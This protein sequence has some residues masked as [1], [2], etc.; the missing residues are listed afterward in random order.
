MWGNNMKRVR[1]TDAPTYCEFED[2]MTRISVFSI[3]VLIGLPLLFGLVS[4]L[5][6][7]TFPSNEAV[8]RAAPSPNILLLTID[9]LRAD[10][11][12]CY[13]Y[14]RETSPVIDALAAEGARFKNAM[15][16][17]GLTWPSLASLMTS[18]YP[19]QHGVRDNGD[20]LAPEHIQLP[21]L[22]GDKGYDTVA[23]LSN[24]HLQHWEGWDLLEHGTDE[25]LTE[26]AV[27]WLN[28]DRPA[29]FFLWLHLMAP[30]WNYTP[31][32]PYDTQFDA[33][34]DG[35]LD[36][37]NGSYVVRVTE[38]GQLSAR[39]VAHMGALYDGEVRYAD[40]LISRILR[41]LT[42]MGAEDNT[43]VIFTA[44]HGEELYDHNRYFD[45]RE[46]V[47]QNV[48]RTPLIVRMPGRIAGGAEIETVVESIDLAPTILEM[49]GMPIPKAFEGRPLRFDPD[50]SVDARGP[51]FSEWEDRILT[52]RDGHSHF[53]FNPS[54]FSPDKLRGGLI[55]KFPIEAYSLYDLESDPREQHNLI[56]KRPEEAARLEVLLDEWRSEYGWTLNEGPY[57]RSLPLEEFQE[58]LRSLGY[59]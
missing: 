39:D 34:Y 50:A 51:A 59:L 28:S 47:Y 42:E 23:F 46:S 4:T 5:A 1:S 57:V 22:L 21:V 43:L 54:A 41:A 17:R 14:E 6:S 49:L 35:P 24:G 10:R 53:I 12:G 8:D 58:H 32:A 20:V 38:R 36:G 45:H 11:L 44:D 18:L 56:D 2:T 19:V 30:H 7:C 3:R 13:G 31:P 55:E 52:V 29:P 48:L 15:A 16:P 33:A 37:G 9:T 25:E 26:R 27:R 40:A